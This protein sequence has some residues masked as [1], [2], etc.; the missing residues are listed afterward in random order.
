MFTELTFPS[1][2]RNRRHISYSCF[3]TYGKR[4]GKGNLDFSPR[5]KTR[6]QRPAM[7]IKI[8]I[9][10]ISF[11]YHFSYYFI[12]LNMKKKIP[13]QGKFEKI[14]ASASQYCHFSYFSRPSIAILAIFPSNIV[15]YFNL[16]QKW[17]QF[18]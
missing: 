2:T 4:H 18:T 14:I 17:L 7:S 13:Y 8:I 12:F 15:I 3:M 16:V 9:I 10:L 5:G 6:L 1:S 11:I